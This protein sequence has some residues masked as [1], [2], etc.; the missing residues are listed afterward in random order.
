MLGSG[1]SLFS[2]LDLPALGYRVKEHASS[3]AATHV[4]VEKGAAP[5]G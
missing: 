4:V 2:G 5:T 1:E 3:E